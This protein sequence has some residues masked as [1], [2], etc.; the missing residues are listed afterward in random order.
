MKDFYKSESSSQIDFQR[1]IK[2]RG[3]SFLNS[4]VQEEETI[5]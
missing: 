3:F 5:A 1:T 2:D 4:N